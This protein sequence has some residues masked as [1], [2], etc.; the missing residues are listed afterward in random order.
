MRHIRNHATS[1][2]NCEANQT[3]IIWKIAEMISERKNIQWP[4]N[5]DITTIMALPF[6]KVRNQDGHVRSGATHLLLII[7]SE[8]AYLI[9]KLRCK[10][11]L[12]TTPD[13]PTC[14]ISPKEAYSQTL[15]IINSRLNQDRILTSKKRYGKKALPE[16]LVL[17]TWCSTLN[18]ESSCPENWLR[19]NGVLVGI[20]FQSI[21]RF[22]I[23]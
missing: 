15:L 20:P 9:W 4:S 17:S 8:C 10:R 6:L 18:D 21:S 5:L 14:T 1:S 19:A 12:D 11:I 13:E 2:F 3:K 7:I 23:G 16:Q 22:G